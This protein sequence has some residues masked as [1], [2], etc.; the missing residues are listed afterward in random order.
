M[1]RPEYQRHANGVEG[2]KSVTIATTDPVLYARLFEG[3]PV[4]YAGAIAPSVAAIRLRVNDRNAAA[5]LLKRGGFSTVALKGGA[6]AV[7]ADQSHGI[8]LVFD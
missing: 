4:I 8:L 5:E 6:L 3:L 1:W 2:I 7:G